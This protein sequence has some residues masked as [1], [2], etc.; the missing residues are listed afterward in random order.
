MGV[1][2]LFKICLTLGLLTIVTES[3]M[4]KKPYQCNERGYYCIF[5]NIN[6]DLSEFLMPR[7]LGIKIKNIRFENSTIQVFS[8]DLCAAFPDASIVKMESLNLLKISYYALQKCF[9]LT[10]ISFENNKLTFIAQNLFENNLELKYISFRKNLLEKFDFQSILH[11]TKFGSLNLAENH[12]TPLIFEKLPILDKIIVLKI[13]SNQLTDLNDQEIVSKFRNL[14]VIDIHD[15]PFNCLRL[16]EIIR[17]F[18]MKFI[19]TNRTCENFIQGIHLKQIWINGIECTL[20][21][22]SQMGNVSKSFM[23]TINRKYLFEI[24]F[25]R[26]KF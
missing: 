22:N 7:D 23:K 13:S 20:D 8:Q 4:T 17:V 1:N 16:L 10:H 12:L 2:N 21:D 15:N 26:L 14:E 6:D 24:V 3:V 18:S 19:S 9:N 25:V 11:L 5:S